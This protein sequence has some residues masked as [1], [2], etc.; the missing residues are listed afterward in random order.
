MA[1]QTKTKAKPQKVEV[2]TKDDEKNV[3]V[4]VD[5]KNEVVT[6]AEE[7]QETQ[8]GFLGNVGGFVKK[9]WKPVV[10]GIALFGAGV[11]TALLMTSNDSS[12][13]DDENEEDDY[14]ILDEEL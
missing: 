10:G 6:V 7:N 12:E 4:E 1:A 8:P 9:V 14:S 13:E 5:E 11:L 2:A 3:V